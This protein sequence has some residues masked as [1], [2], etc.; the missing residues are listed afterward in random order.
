[1]RNIV[2]QAEEQRFD[3][4]RGIDQRVPYQGATCDG[5]IERIERQEPR[6]AIAARRRQPHGIAANVIGAIDSRAGKRWRLG[7]IQARSLAI[8]AGTPDWNGSASAGIYCA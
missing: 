4:G 1:M 7:S 6:P 5:R 8:A 2:D 3:I